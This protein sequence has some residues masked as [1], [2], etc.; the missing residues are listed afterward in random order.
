[1]LRSRVFRIWW[2][3]SRG[4]KTVKSLSSTLA[5]IPLGERPDAVFVVESGVYSG[6]AFSASTEATSGP[7]G[8]LTFTYDLAWF[9]RNVTWAAPRIT[10]YRQVIGASWL[11]D[12]K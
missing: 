4:P 3:V 2:L 11:R 1:M 10:P 7:A 5:N 9:V 8:F 12:K 6:C